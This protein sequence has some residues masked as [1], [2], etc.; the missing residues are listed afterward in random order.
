MEI[1]YTSLAGLVT[2]VVGSLVSWFMAKKKYYSEV[3]NQ[4]IKNMKES[5]EFYKTLSDDNKERL[6]EQ[7]DRNDKLEAQILEMQKQIN[8]LQNQV[9]TMM[10]QICLQVTCNKRIR[11]NTA[12]T[13]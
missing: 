9:M 10:G 2:T 13:K 4:T 6:Q 7:I 11:T 5:L 1:I 8:L 3:D 12:K